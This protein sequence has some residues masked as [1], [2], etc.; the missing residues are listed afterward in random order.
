MVVVELL[1]TMGPSLVIGPRVISEVD[2]REL[3]AGERV[4]LITAHRTGNNFNVFISLCG[5][6]LVR[7]H[8]LG[9]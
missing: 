4:Q 8:R 6:L 2:L 1:P 3:S 9:S 7:T 5:C